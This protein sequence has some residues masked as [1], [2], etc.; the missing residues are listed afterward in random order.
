MIILLANLWLTY[1]TKTR[2]KSMAKKDFKGGI[3]T[4]IKRTSDEQTDTSGKTNSVDESIFNKFCS[5]H[6][7]YT[8]NG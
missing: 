4:L 5:R 2:L 1:R 6:T 8:R 7:Y 3:S